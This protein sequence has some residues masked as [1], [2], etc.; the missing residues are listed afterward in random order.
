MIEYYDVVVGAV[1]LLVLLLG[2]VTVA[3]KLGMVPLGERKVATPGSHVSENVKGVFPYLDDLLTAI[4]RV[5]KAGYSDFTVVSPLPR[6]E[7]EEAIYDNEPSPVRWWTLFGGIFGGTGGFVLAAMT[8][9]VW[10]M[11]LPGGKPVVSIPPFVIITF[12]CTVL[13]AGLMSLAAIIYHCRLPA[14]D[15]DVEVCDPRFSSDR[16]GLVVHG[17][18]AEERKKA[19]QLL[20]DAGAEEVAMPVEA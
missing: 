9:A 2:G 11:A 12:E 18:D 17:L 10:P 5:R 14:F 8:S 19:A 3:W 16:F 20:N 4:G 13:I 7:I 15:L 6:H 1:A